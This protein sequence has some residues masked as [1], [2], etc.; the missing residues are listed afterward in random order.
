MYI[1]STVSYNACPS[2][3]AFRFLLALTNQSCDQGI[4]GL[5]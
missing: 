4:Y 1:Y 3:R 5:G 2:G